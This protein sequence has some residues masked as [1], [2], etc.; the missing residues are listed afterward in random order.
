MAAD[1]APDLVARAFGDEQ[2]ADDSQGGKEEVRLKREGFG[3]FPPFEELGKDADNDEVSAD[4]NAGDGELEDLLG[5]I[6]LD[7]EKSGAKEP[8]EEE[9]A[10]DQKCGAVNNI[11]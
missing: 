11:E 7:A 3:P 9:D 2:N 5:W 6:N 8:D 4:E 10:G 1:P